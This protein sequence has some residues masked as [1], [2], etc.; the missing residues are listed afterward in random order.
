MYIYLHII[1]SHWYYYGSHLALLIPIYQARFHEAIWWH[2]YEPVWNNFKKSETH[3]RSIVDNHRLSWRS[4]VD[5]HRNIIVYHAQG[6]AGLVGSR[7][8]I[9]DWFHV[10]MIYWNSRPGIICDICYYTE[11]SPTKWNGRL[12]GQTWVGQLVLPVAIIF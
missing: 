4:I 6:H 11:E 5:N 9:K 2:N 7:D 1:K 12:E 10:L 8:G 3:W